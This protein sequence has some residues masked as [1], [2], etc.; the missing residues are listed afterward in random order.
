MKKLIITLFLIFMS[1]PAMA[2]DAHEHVHAHESGQVQLK[3]IEGQY[4]CMVNN[5]SYDSPQIAVDVEGKTYYGCCSMCEA[6]L[7]KDPA[8]RVAVDPVSGKTVDKTEA[9]I[10][11]DAENSV[12]Y[13]ESVENLKAF[14]RNDHMSDPL[15]HMEHMQ[16]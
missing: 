13:F 14:K 3:Q 9:V 11:S 6:R 12:Y 10:G 7:K 1:L 8:I 16:H 15:E 5:K 4:V 2:Q